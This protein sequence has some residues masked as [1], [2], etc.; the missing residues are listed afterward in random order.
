MPV[1][2]EAAEPEGGAL[3]ALDEVVDRF[4]RAVGD[5]GAVPVHDGGVPATEGAAQAAQLR[6]AVGVGEVGGEF[7]EVGAGELGAVDVIEAAEGFLGVPCQ[8]DLAA[9]VAGCEQAA[10]L[11]V[12]AFAEP[13][14]G[15][16]EQ[17]PRP[18]EGIVFAA[19]VAEGVVLGF[20]GAP[21]RCCCS[22][23]G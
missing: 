18:I 11:G 20:C 14:M 8:A 17:P 5:P 19:A 22:P 3:D 21:R 7:S 23:G 10:E 2:R 16:N 15:R 4:G 1:V 12:A 6:R 9:G 13:F